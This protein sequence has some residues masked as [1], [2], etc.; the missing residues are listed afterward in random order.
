[1]NFLVLVHIVSLHLC[2]S[3]DLK[4]GMI[5]PVNH[6]YYNFHIGFGTSAGAVGLA[7]D[8]VE[9]EQLLPDANISYNAC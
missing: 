5:A 9:Q 3:Y 2:F 6:P 7:L 1:M 8:R 4:I